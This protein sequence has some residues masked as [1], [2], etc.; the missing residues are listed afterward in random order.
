MTIKTNS[1]FY[2]VKCKCGSEKK[3]FSHVNQQVKCDSCKEILA[4][5]S[6]GKAIFM[7]KIISELDK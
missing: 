3:I 1:R 4:E 2:L 5:S 7:G 6:G